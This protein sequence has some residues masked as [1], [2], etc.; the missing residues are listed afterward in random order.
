MIYK[1]IDRWNK[2]SLYHKNGH[3]YVA[4]VKTASGTRYFYSTDEYNAFLRTKDYSEDNPINTRHLKIDRNRTIMIPDQGKQSPTGLKTTG[5]TVTGGGGIV[6]GNPKGYD[7]NEREYY[8]PHVSKNDKDPRWA[9]NQSYKPRATKTE[10]M[11]QNIKNKRAKGRRWVE[12][13]FSSH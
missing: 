7:F 11:V 8:T 12:K 2:C 5:V 1:G 9:R 10:K 4:K 6:G 13:Y 3:K